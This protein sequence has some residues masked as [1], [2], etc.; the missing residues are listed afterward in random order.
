MK[1]VS[2]IIPKVEQ[3]AGRPIR[4]QID[5]SKVVHQLVPVTRRGITPIALHIWRSLASS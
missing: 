5:N 1:S 3:L 2:L 4:E